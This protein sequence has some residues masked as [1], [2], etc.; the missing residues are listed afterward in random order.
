VRS[1]STFRRARRQGR[2]AGMELCSE[3]WSTLPSRPSASVYDVDVKISVDFALAAALARLDASDP[4]AAAELARR[5]EAAKREGRIVI[6]MR[7][8]QAAAT[9]APSIHDLLARNDRL[10][11]AGLQPSPLR[12][13]NRGEPL[14]P[15]G[16]GA[17]LL[18]D[19]AAPEMGR[20]Y[21]EP[22]FS[23]TTAV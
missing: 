16:A 3:G 13:P 5:A 10:G 23:R 17:T 20:P 8:P 21:R 19:P 2:Q 15:F 6:S 1:I 12:S 4:I 9:P 22:R 14:G 7:E 18:T 11:A